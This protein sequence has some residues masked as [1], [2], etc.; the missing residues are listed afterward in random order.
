M[1][2]TPDAAKIAFADILAASGVELIQYRNKQAPSGSLLQIS[3]NLVKVLN[4]R[5]VRVIVNDRPDIA[6][7]A[8]AGGV[9][10][11]QEDLQVEDARAMCGTERWVGVSTH[12][13]D[14]VREASKTSAD[15]IAVGP[16]FATDT[17]KNPDPIVG[18]DFIRR[19]RQLTNKPLVAIGGINL[20]RAAEAFIAGADSV[21]GARD[22]LNVPD[23][24][25]RAS[26]VLSLAPRD[27]GKGNRGASRLSDV[28]PAT[29][30]Q[31][32]LAGN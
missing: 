30:A 28:T 31:P 25:P 1:S 11:G 26:Q 17:K 15:Y 3:L 5:H 24:R 10:V 12:T 20:E 19:A 16:I 4:P 6:R 14:Q 18:V 7:L 23:P 13:L 8:D 29:A 22:L 32:H 9:H 27:L 21:A 2:S